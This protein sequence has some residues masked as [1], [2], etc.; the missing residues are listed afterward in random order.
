MENLQDG[1]WKFSWV[2]QQWENDEY[3]KVQDLFDVPWFFK[4][5]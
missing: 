4:L 1:S 2:K 5:S 3:K